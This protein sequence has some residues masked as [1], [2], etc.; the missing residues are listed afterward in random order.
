[1]PIFPN[2]LPKGTLQWQTEDVV[3]YND[4]AFFGAKPGL[5]EE[6]AYE[7]VKLH[8]DHAGEFARYHK[9]TEA[10]GPKLFVM[11]LTKKNTHPGAIRA[12]KDAGIT[13]PER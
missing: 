8:L 12:Y 6:L 9:T 10:Y 11:G 7:F 13:I 3:G 2:K 5:Q 1:M 4:L